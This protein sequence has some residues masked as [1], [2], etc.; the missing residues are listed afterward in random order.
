[1][2]Q[3]QYSAA[4]SAKCLPILHQRGKCSVALRLPQTHFL[5]MPFFSHLFTVFTVMLSF[6]ASHELICRCLSAGVS[7][8]RRGSCRACVHCCCV[9]LTMVDGPPVRH[10]IVARPDPDVVFLVSPLCH[11]DLPKHG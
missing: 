1:M 4:L 7:D 9:S 11:S 10:P 3:M 6:S 8:G 2:P 5:L